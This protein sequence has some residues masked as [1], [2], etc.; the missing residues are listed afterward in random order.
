MNCETSPKIAKK[1]EAELRANPEFF[2]VKDSHEKNSDK[3]YAHNQDTSFH[4]LVGRIGSN[5]IKLSYSERDD[6]A[7]VRA[8]VKS[9]KNLKKHF[10][11][12][13]ELD[14]IKSSFV[15]SDFLKARKLFG[16]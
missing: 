15:S 14:S 1:L 12:L 6:S 9:L 11:T 3:D 16:E 5:I 13:E 4:I 7:L 8:D 10:S 2:V